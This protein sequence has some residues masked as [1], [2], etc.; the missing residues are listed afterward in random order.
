MQLINARL[1]PKN[2]I[3]HNHMKNGYYDWEDLPQFYPLP[4]GFR[5][6]LFTPKA[7]KVPFY[8]LLWRWKIPEA[9]SYR[10]A[11]M[12]VLITLLVIGWCLHIIDQALGV[13]VII[14]V[15]YTL[16]YRRT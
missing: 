10:P 13:C 9:S 4:L 8:T 12:S 6:S 14:D 11:L 16:R 15:A 7:M 3:T 1:K 5:Q 2:A